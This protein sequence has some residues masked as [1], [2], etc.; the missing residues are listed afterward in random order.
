MR[1]ITIEQEEDVVRLYRSEKY[2]I[3]QICKMTNVLSEQTI[4]R[5]LKERNIP[6]RNIRN[7]TK[8]VS[9]SLDYET[10]L[11]LDKIKPKNLSKYICDIIKDTELLIK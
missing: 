9:V 8:K 3:K 4:Y 11:I 7:I 2:T 10:E 5:I 1:L 6:K